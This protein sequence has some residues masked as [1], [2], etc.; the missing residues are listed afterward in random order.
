MSKDMGRRNFLK[1]AGGA[2]GLSAL[3]Y[4]L[5]VT[6]RVVPPPPAALPDYAD[7]QSGFPVFRG[8]YLQKDA[9]LAAFLF[10]ANPESLT[11][12]CD[13]TLNF[14]SSF[15][16]KYIP[17]TSSVMVVFADMLVSS[18]DERDSQVGLIPET[19]VSFWV[20][21]A[22]MQETQGGYVPHHLAWFLPFLL[23]DDGNSIA[24]GRE[25]FGFNKLAAQFRKPDLI[26][27]PAYSADVLG[28]K[29]FGTDIIAQRE[30]LLELSPASASDVSRPSDLNSIKNGMAAELFRNMR[31]NL[32]GGLVEFAARF[33]NDHIP[34]VFL[35]QFRAAQDTRK[36]C[37]QRLIEAPLKVETF[38]EGG[39]FSEPYTLNI[40]SLASHPL[41]QSLGLQAANQKSTLGAWMHVD[42]VLG[43]GIEI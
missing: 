32:G 38:F 11:T 36:A 22:A 9:R 1:L 13:Q 24:T 23:V 33:L 25:V 3:S 10:N 18:R 20:L 4:F 26:Q 40:A 29:Q 7:H 39:L 37:Y 17:M 35:K 5:G 16:Y 42:F 30:R 27:K 28:F 2:F 43:N 12:L 14:S 31:T 8:P 6:K 21:T 15:L 19:E 41:A 34:L